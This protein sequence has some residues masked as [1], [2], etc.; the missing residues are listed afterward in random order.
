MLRGVKDLHGS[1]IHAVD[2]EIGRVDEI[3]FDDEHWTVRYLIVDTG[4]WLLGHKVLISPMTVGL[5]D[6]ERRSLT[7]NLTR[8]QVENSPGVEADLPVSRQWEKSYYDY[9]AWPY[10][11]GGMGSL[12]SMYY[13]TMMPAAAAL[14]DAAAIPSE[15]EEHE[16]DHFDRHLR[17]TKEMTGYTLSATDGHIG[18]IQDFIVDDATWRIRYLDVDTLNVWQGKRVLLPPDWIGEADWVERTVLVDVTREQVRNAPEWDTAV[19]ITDAFEQQLY[20][21]YARQPHV[22]HG[23][24]RDD[25]GLVLR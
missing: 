15:D 2:G 24:A 23:S 10:Y 18:Q 22:D 8:E 1:T 14:D 12:G 16:R 13:P 6:W 21:Y 3:L 5:R 9:Y 25:A 19:P 11:W 7:V 4:G 20:E 17:S